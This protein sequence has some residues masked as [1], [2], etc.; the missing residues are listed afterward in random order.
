MPGALVDLMLQA[1]GHEALELPLSADLARWCGPGHPDPRRPNN[2][3]ANPGKRDASLL[4]GGRLVRAP[5]HGRVDIDIGDPGW[6]ADF[7]VDRDDPPHDPEMGARQADGGDRPQRIEQRAAS[8]SR[9]SSK[10][11]QGRPA[12]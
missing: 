8:L 9:A 5:R 2:L 10:P 12:A 7:E 3:L 6:P 1:C 4:E 11:R